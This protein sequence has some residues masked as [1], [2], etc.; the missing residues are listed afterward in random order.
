[1]FLLMAYGFDKL[2]YQRFVWRCCS[3]NIASRN[4]AIRIG[5]RPEGT[6]RRAAIVRGVPMDIDWLSMMAQ[7]W[8]E[9]RAAILEWLDRSDF[10]ERG[11]VQRSLRRARYD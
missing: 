2:N 10:T 7:G 3:P 4:A 1:I 9:R 5:F 8:P 6:W 11:I